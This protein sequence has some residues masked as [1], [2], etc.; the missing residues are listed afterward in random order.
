MKSF[1]ALL[2]IASFAYL[3]VSQ[4]TCATAPTGCSLCAGTPTGVLGTIPATLAN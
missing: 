2:V 4:S 1:V 3:A